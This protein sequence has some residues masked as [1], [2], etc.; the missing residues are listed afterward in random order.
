[1][2]KTHGQT[3]AGHDF[4]K[5]NQSKWIT[6][7]FLSILLAGS[8][9]VIFYCE[10]IQKLPIG[11]KRAILELAGCFIVLAL[12][13]FSICML[14]VKKRIETPDSVNEW[15]KYLLA[16]SLLA[17]FCL[18]W[19][20]FP[21]TGLYGTHT[22]EI[23]PIPS[24]D[25]GEITPVTLTW[26]K[27]ENGDV[28]LDSFEGEGW[29]ERQADGIV[30]YDADSVI[31]WTGRTG[32]IVQM[33]FKA[34]EEGGSASYSWDGRTVPISLYNETMD[35]LSYERAF[36][37]PFQLPEFVAW[38]LILL[39]FFTT[40]GFLLF[41][42]QKRIPFPAFFA[43]TALCFVFFRVAQFRMPDELVTR[44][45][46]WGYIGISSFSLRDIFTGK[47]YCFDEY[48]CQNRP[49]LVPLF[50]KLCR[51]NL[52]AISIGQLSFSLISWIFF[53]WQSTKAI[54]QKTVQAI[55]TIALFG[56]ASVPNVTRWDKVI[57]SESLSI[58]LTVLF[59][60]W[61]LRFF[62]AEAQDGWHFRTAIPLMVTSL[63]LLLSRDSNTW[64]ILFCAL[65]IIL[66][67]FRKSRRKTAWITAAILLVCCGV[68]LST[69]GD[70]WKYSYFNVLFV[71]IFNDPQAEAFFMDRGMP[72]PDEVNAL[73]GYK[74]T[75]TFPEFN[76]EG[77]QP[78]RQWVKDNGM[79][80][81]VEYLLT[82]FFDTV[83][84]PWNEQFEPQAFEAI[85][86]QY[87]QE[88]YQ[89]LMPESWIK[90]FMLNGTG[91]G[92]ILLGIF[93][94]FL[95]IGKNRE[96]QMLIPSAFVV[97]GFFFCVL[98]YSLDAYD[99]ARQSVETIIMM[100]VSLWILLARLIDLLFNRQGLS[101]TSL[102]ENA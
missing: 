73:K 64:L 57:L 54:K 5:M 68:T 12:S 56:F 86:S 26:L 43:V 21:Q 75:Q 71:R 98:I 100:K 62:A 34:G 95:S 9:A 44:V 69:T 39:F 11:S 24:E 70:R 37:K 61:L 89:S 18:V 40:V 77:M 50:Y 1:M 31:R 30:A 72:R 84:N 79:R 20:P 46:T 23:R 94:L 36:P 93:G 76:S 7:L 32:A 53:I 49:I 66:S 28:S 41:L 81:Y 51:Q 80:V 8:G 92:T 91:I 13:F 6:S 35:R 78:L 45:D 101:P 22:L 14:F 55:L 96:E 4:S 47:A 3:T 83:R 82:R 10:H 63:L 52:T 87:K 58:S 90:F 48:Y 19:L 97:I 27:T 85:D 17:F 33:E 29:W 15:A 99:F 67:G 2:V 38:F 25:G 60:G 42:N 65:L 16:G 59:L 88:D 102:N 74:H